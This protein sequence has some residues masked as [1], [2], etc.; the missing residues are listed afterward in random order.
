MTACEAL[1]VGEVAAVFNGKTPSKAQQREI[2]HPVLKIKDVDEHGRFR[3][4]FSGHVDPELAAKHTKQQIEGGETLIL[5]AAHSS[6][7]VASKTFFADG[8]VAGA[9]A[10]GEW[11]MMRWDKDAVDPRYGN[12]WINASETRFRIRRLVN[13][14]HLYPKDIARLQIPLPPLDEQKRIAGIL[15]AADE[16]RAKRRA[17]LALLDDLLQSTFLDMFGDPVSNPM[18]WEA[19]AIGEIAKAKGG[20]R[21]PKGEEYAEESTDYRYIRVS[22]LRPNEIQTESLKYLKPET[23]AKISRYTVDPG[24]VVISIAGTIG[25]TAAVPDELA[26]ANLTENAAKIVFKDKGAVD[27]VYVSYALQMPHAQYQIRGQTGQV[28]IGKLALF[29]I[30]KIVIPLPPL[31]LQQ[32]F[33]D[34]VEAVEQQKTRYQAHLDELDTLFS[35]L[36][37]RAFQGEL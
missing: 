31:D 14:I 18:G 22:D 8:T 19:K 30:E 11:L 33:A 25:I 27:A 28:T 4:S 7:H 32:R 2:G 1:R 15:D 3:G 26:G 13:G 24:D 36:Q 37:S 9:L 17:S 6:T 20:K 23:Q 12:H 34:I 5:N 35:S 10:T 21:L 16:L 29:R